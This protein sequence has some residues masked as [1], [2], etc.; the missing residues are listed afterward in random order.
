M[1]F[2]HFKRRG[3]LQTKLTSGKRNK[4]NSEPGGQIFTQTFTKTPCATNYVPGSHGT[5]WLS[6]NYL[7]RVGS[8]VLWLIL[9]SSCHLLCPF[10]LDTGSWQFLLGLFL[11]FF[12]LACGMWSSQAKGW[13]LHHSNDPSRRGDNARSWTRHTTRELW[14]QQVFR[15]QLWPVITALRKV[16]QWLN[17][18]K[19][20]LTGFSFSSGF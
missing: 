16:F 11:I 8:V 9:S 6:T 7:L 18:T 10:L 19:K 1:W 2:K 3:K 20:T 15:K 14:E 4:R 5:Q 17:F 13:N 12:G